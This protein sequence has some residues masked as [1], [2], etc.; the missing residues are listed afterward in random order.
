MH[1]ARTTVAGAEA[2][3]PAPVSIISNFFSLSINS[4]TYHFIS[5]HINS[6]NYGDARRVISIS[7]ALSTLMSFFA[8]LFVLIASTFIPKTFFHSYAYSRIIKLLGL[9]LLLNVINMTPVA[10]LNV[11]QCFRV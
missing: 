6:G 1:Y 3:M 8:L 2:L 10:V 11:L 9:E 7:L 4:G 5:F